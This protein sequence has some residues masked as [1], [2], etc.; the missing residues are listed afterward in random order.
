[1]P[2][3]D[4]VSGRATGTAWRQP[5]RRGGGR[6]AKGIASLSGNARGSRVTSKRS[7]RHAWPPPCAAGLQV[8]W[9]LQAKLGLGAVVRERRVCRQVAARCLLCAACRVSLRRVLAWAAYCGICH[10]AGALSAWAG[11]GRLRHLPRFRACGV[12]GRGPLP[13]ATSGLSVVGG[14]YAYSSAFPCAPDLFRLK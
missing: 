11:V 7:P 2:G 8:A 12:G 6:V 13:L 14:P 4:S 10:R 5:G 3:K 1:V 9:S